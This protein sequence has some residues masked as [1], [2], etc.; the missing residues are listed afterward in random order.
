[1]VLRNVQPTFT[2]E[3]QRVEINELAADVDS[4]NTG[5]N[6]TDWDTA[7]SWGNHAT[8]NYIVNNTFSNVTINAGIT[9]RNL[10]I[11]DDGS[12]SPIFIS[13]ADDTS[14]WNLSLQNDGYSTNGGTGT[15]YFMASDGTAKWYHYG[16]SEFEN[17][18]FYT[19][20]VVGSPSSHL[21][22]RLD[23]FGGAQL[24]YQGNYRAGSTSWGLNVDGNLYASEGMDI[25]D[26][27][28][29][30]A[31]N[32]DDLRLGHNATSSYIDNYTGSLDI[33]NYADDQDITL[34]TDSGTGGIA[35]YIRCDGSSGAVILGHYGTEKFTTTSGGVEISGTIDL[36]SSSSVIQLN[37]WADDNAP[38][39][40][41]AANA[42]AGNVIVKGNGA[43]SVAAF[44]VYADGWSG[45]DD[46]YAAIYANGG[47]L[48]KAPVVSD[49]TATG[50]AGYGYELKNGATSLGGLYKTSSNGGYLQL[51]NGSGTQTTYINGEDGSAVFDGTL[52]VDGVL[53]AGQRLVVNQEG[54]KTGTEDTFLNYAGDGTTVT[55]AITA[56]GAATFS[57]SLTIGSG[58]AA[59]DDYG[60]IAYADS[61]SLSNKSAVY[62]RNL[63]SGGRTFTGD[64]D[65]GA[66]TFEV[67]ANGTVNASGTVTAPF[68]RANGS[69]GTSADTMLLQNTTSGGDNRVRIN[70]Y[71][72]GGGDPYLKFDAGGSNMIVGLEYN[73]STNN[74]L[75]MG[76]GETP[77]GVTG[78]TIN[79][80]GQTVI[81]SYTLG[82]EQLRVVGDEADI[83]LDSSGSGIWRIMGSTGGGT[84]EFRI[85]D[86]T[87]SS[88]RVKINSSGRV[89]LP[90]IVGVAGSNI[91]NVS[92]ES[93]GNLVTTT[94]I[95]AAKTNISPLADTSWL[96]DLNPVTFNWRTKTESE[97]GTL[98]WGEEADGGTQYG[99]IAEEVKEVNDDF[100]YYSTDGELTGV[101]YDRLVAPLLKV[102]QQQKEQIEALQA[103]LDAAGI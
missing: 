92:V 3:E 38:A 41:I 88:D 54:T 29:F 19:A 82:S 22:F 39:V 4:I 103:R 100:C 1:M 71:A 83:W 10:T 21:A 59:P 95:R 66:T 31:G 2:F 91:V 57:E 75:C 70:T 44:A 101:H 61:D 98:S 79:G 46:L 76:V 17:T 74:K 8:Q 20:R 63:N 40:R 62:A 7:F 42:N 52:T 36:P 14:V 80:L 84:H 49:P 9:T 85:Y 5:Y 90:G 50:V 64:N 87:N 32:S 67:Y 73:G 53:T 48:F 51:N 78:I 25:P 72:N 13:R 97:D 94:S 43:S 23:T 15:K 60:L 77:S 93:D 6:N 45:T 26:N 58:S 18:E 33:S 86:D 65:T 16:Y 35:T 102:V 24:M 28:S 81:G 68:I 69:D 34:R 56:D 27:Y 99:L 55:A 12:S 37:T 96:F 30:H 89:R 11:T 47:A